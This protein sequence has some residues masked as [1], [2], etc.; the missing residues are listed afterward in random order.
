MVLTTMGAAVAQNTYTVTNTDDSGTGSFRWAVDQVNA[1][2]N[3]AII[4][5]DITGTGPHVIQPQSQ[6][7][8]FTNSVTVDGTTQTGYADGA[9]VIVFDGSL[10]TDTPAL[11]FTNSA[12]NSIVRGLSIINF[13]SF[14]IRLV[15]GG[16][17]IEG[18]FIGLDADGNVAGNG[19]GISVTSTTGNQIGGTNASQRNVISGNNIGIDLEAG[20]GQNVIEGNYIGTTSDGSASAGN[21]FNLQIRGS[22]NNTVGGSTAAQR[23]VISGAF[24]EQVDG[25]NEGGSGI[26]IT[27]GF[28][29]PDNRILPTGNTVQGNYI[30]T[31]VTGT[32]ALPNERAGVLLLFGATENKIGGSAAGEGNLVSG[33]GLYGI[34][35]QGSLE[36]PVESND[37]E[38]NIIGLNAS[39]TADLGNTAGVFLWGENNSNTIGETTAGSANIIAGNSSTGVVLFEGG[40]GNSVIGNRIGLNSSGDPFG[41]GGSGVDI[42][43]SSGNFI[44][45][46]LAGQG[47]IIANNTLDG[48]EVTDSGGILSLNNSI[49]GNQ[50]YANGGIGIDLAGDGITQNDDLDT[51]SGPNNLQNSPDISAYSLSSDQ[52]SITYSL[53]SDPANT[54]YPVRVEF[55]RPST[56]FTQARTYLGSDSYTSTDY[57]SGNKFVTI[58]LPSPGDF[59]DGDLLVATATDAAGNTS[60]LSAA[61]TGTSLFVVTNTNDSGA[62]S[63]REA[64]TLSNFSPQ[65]STIQFNIPG[66][67]P[68]SIAPNSPLPTLNKPVTINGTSQ[69]G[70]FDGSLEPTPVIEINGTNAGTASGLELNGGNSNVLALVINNFSGNGI[71]IQQNGGNSIVDNF[72]G[73]TSSGDAAA[74]NGSAGVFIDNVPNNEIVG[75]LISGNNSGIFLQLAG[76]TGNVLQENIIG[77]DLAGNTAI[78]NEVDGIRL[79]NGPNGNE[80]VDNLISGNGGNGIYIFD[81]LGFGTSNNNVSAN[82]VGTNALTT[83]R[84]PNFR[85]GI[86]IE[87]SGNNQINSNVLSGN[88]SNGLEINGSQSTGNVV[89]GNIIGLGSDGV[90]KVS[91]RFSGVALV[92]AVNNTLGGD[93]TSFGN[94]ISGN[95]GIFNATLFRGGGVLISGTASGNVIQGN[96]IGTDL[97]GAPQ[98]DT[99]NFSDGIK[100]Q[101]GA[102]NNIIGLDETGAG[103]R[104]II[105]GNGEIDES[106]VT[107]VDNNS[108]NNRISGNSIFGNLTTGIDLGGDGTTDNDADDSVTGPNNLQ[109]FPVLTSAVYD[110]AVSQLT[111]TFSVPSDPANSDYPLRIEFYKNSGN[112][113]GE[114]Y[115]G[116][117]QYETADFGSEKEVAVSLTAND[118]ISE[119]DQVTALAIS[120]TGN[121]SEFGGTVLVESALTAPNAPV[122]ATPSD[123]ATDVAVAPLFSWQASADAATYEIQVSTASDFSSTVVNETGVTAIEFQAPQLAYSTGYFWRV[124]AVNE[125]GQSD[126]ST[127][128]SFTTEAEPLSPPEVVTLSSPSDNASDVAVAP[129]FTWQASADAETYDI[130]VSTASDFSGTVVNETGIAATEFQ[131]PQLAYSTG[132]FWRV[133]AVNEAGQSDWSTVWSFTTEAEPLSPPEVVTLSS[134]SDNASDVAVAPLFTWQASADAETYDIQVSTASDFSGTVVNE[135]GIAATEFQSPQLAYST[136]YFWRV[137]AVNASGQS[138][139]STVWSFTTEAEPLSPPGVVTLSA[140][141]DA[142]VDVTISP[143]LSWQASTDA[144]SYIVQVSLTSDFAAPII[145]QSGITALELTV[146]D[147]AYES[148]HFWRVRAVNASGQSDWSTVWSFTTEAEPLSPPGVVTL[149]SPADG[150]TDVSVSPLFTWQASTDAETYDIQV[151]TASDFSSTAVNETGIAAT[152]FQAPALSYSTGYFWRVRAVNAAGQSDWSTV[153]S[154]TTVANQPPVANDDSYTTRPGT[155]LIVDAAT[156]LLANDTDPDG[157]PLTVQSIEAP[158]N[159]VINIATDGSFEYTP[160]AGF[161]G[162]ETLTYTITDGTATATGT[163]TIAVENQPP[164]ANDDSYTTRPG[165][166]LIVDAATGLLA[167]DTDPD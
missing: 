70:Y 94:L 14:A 147:L 116:S 27:S 100:I 18:N 103:L 91:N 155:D 25:Q 166:D 41:N 19:T 130:Q 48:V 122:L 38:G 107:V 149:S 133:R 44:G 64:M 161:T 6:Y 56:D 80:I 136:G 21:K 71:E 110:G 139:W 77:L 16:S 138:D 111:S 50:I 34:Y 22:S 69:P 119:G 60:E 76:A 140:P 3:P 89:T 20:S 9:P 10:T 124:R 49:L 92:D 53:N 129:L 12:D 131:S 40:T 13:D 7:T 46:T 152:E 74:S 65:A 118:L 52:L 95:G 153:W 33:N 51:D 113:Q 143:T 137:R 24:F 73:T 158:V 55:F 162:T 121:T 81:I 2:A 128:W 141:S 151:S 42:E 4:A 37:I 63:L 54:A 8:S 159:G 47:N 35:L 29:S 126:W 59:G 61:V 115:L 30:G 72:I 146:S 109:N 31:D 83:S 106:G 78:P 75:N 90:T 135:T 164:V 154:F 105:A 84:I 86:R 57:S 108:L 117:A 123:N 97:N 39:E 101:Q 66:D 82:R 165:T 132:Y 26:V 125:A 98:A 85:D 67:P 163:V 23:N 36:A 32:V 43:G 45:G 62:G 1:D 112:R 15:G 68:Y 104:N 93:D 145:D 99:G 17:T 142:A 87:Q 167:N 157:D 148:Q 127:V 58:T 120:S 28:L 96:F 11:V 144:A 79:G 5:F 102:S 150:A 114:V 156:G 160:D 134:P 88:D